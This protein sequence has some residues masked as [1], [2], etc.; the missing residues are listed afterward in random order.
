[1]IVSGGGE[2]LVAAAEHELSHDVRRHVRI[3]GLSEIAVRGAADEPALALRIVPSRRFSIWYNRGRWCA[4]ALYLIGA[5]RILLRL[6]LS[7]AS[8]L[9]AAAPSV[10]AIVVALSG[11][12]VLIAFALLR[13]AAEGLRIV[14]LLLLL[15]LLLLI[16]ST[17]VAG[18]VRRSGGR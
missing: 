8:A 18:S 17:A 16:S 10:M 5:R 3:A 4:V 13:A 7:S 14:V 15:L 12:A 11:V 6:A 9:I 2:N 1:M